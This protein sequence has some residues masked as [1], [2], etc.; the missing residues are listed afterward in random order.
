MGLTKEECLRNL[1]RI[2]TRGGNED[3]FLS[4]YPY[5]KYEIDYLFKL[6]DEHF[7]TVGVGK[8]A[9]FSEEGD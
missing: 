7:G 9:R 8:D 6:I 3:E 1:K 4:L 5:F 2:I